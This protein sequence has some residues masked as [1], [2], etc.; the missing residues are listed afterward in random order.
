MPLHS[1][2]STDGVRRFPAT[3]GE[4][5]LFFWL[6]LLLGWNALRDLSR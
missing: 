4:I 6:S 1:P 2:H 3:V 5:S